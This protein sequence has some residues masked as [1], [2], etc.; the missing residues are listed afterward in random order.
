MD[1]SGGNAV[2]SGRINGAM[3]AVLFLTAVFFVNYTDR[4]ILGPLLV[5]M[6]RSLNLDHVQ[7]TSLLLF[8]STGFSCGLL[9]SGFVTA[10][11]APRKI[12]AFSAIGSGIM[13]LCI[14]RAHSLW[15][16]RLFFAL[17]GFVS[18]TYM[19]AAMATLGSLVLPAN[20]S[21]AVAVHELSP[22]VSFIFSPLLAETIA[23]Y[24]GWQSAMVVM[25]VLSIAMGTLFLLFGKGG[26]EKTERPS[27]GGIAAALKT[28]VFWVFIWLFALAVGGEFAPYSVLPLSLTSEQG[29]GSMEA[30]QLLSLS[31]VASPFVVLLGGVAAA[32]LGVVRAIFLFLAV[33]GI[34]LMA[35]ALPASLVGKPGLLAAMACQSMT[36]AFAFPALF[37]LLARAF[38][39]GQQAML[40]SLSLP[41]ATY[42]GGGMV[43]MLLG[44]CGEYL[45]FATGYFL[46][47]LLCLATIPSLRLC[48]NV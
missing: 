34:A 36:T 35:M 2:T 31:R 19:P 44:V 3:P 17:L 27:A 47:G 37:A 15:E 4:A 46:F 22:A 18:G 28:P 43:P 14:S 12:V 10:S 45:S 48:K 41:V 30:S 38:P 20:W 16:V 5:H 9:S 1:I 23:T 6:E 26:R 29:L 32:R 21:T 24:K 25:G 40:L 7:A 8:L 39:I 13:L 33:H 11:V 42:L